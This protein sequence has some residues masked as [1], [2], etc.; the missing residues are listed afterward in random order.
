M[1]DNPAAY[2]AIR[3]PV[4]A[5]DVRVKFALLVAV[6][7]AV[8]CVHS[9][10]GL[11]I[12]AAGVVACAVL[13][14]VPAAALA[15]QLAFVWVLLAIGLAGSSF[16]FDVQAAHELLAADP[17]T[18]S[19]AGALAVL[20]P[21]P[22]AGSFGF[23]P[24]GCGRGYFAVV[25][26]VVLLLASLVLTTTSTQAQISAGLRSMLSP[27]SRVGL[28]AHDAAT[29]VSIALR[30]I[31]VSLSALHQVRQ[32]HLCRAS[33]LYQGGPVRRLGAWG[34]VFIALFVGLFRQARALSVAMDARCYGSADATCLNAAPAHAVSK[35][36]LVL[37]IAACVAVVLAF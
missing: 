9:W 23:V 21:V 30:F 31:P 8:F 16:S 17:R 6:S 3:T 18:A 10:A 20:P 29:V 24:A 1:F 19:E 22:L 27:L 4:H 7:V 14:R 37:G 36:L 15:R 34:K 12:L 11:A 32:A 28:P 5:V 2:Q 35:V 33:A 13:A 26:V 25:R